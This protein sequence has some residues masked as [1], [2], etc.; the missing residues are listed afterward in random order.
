MKQLPM[1]FKPTR[2]KK[3]ETRMIHV[4]VT[5]AERERIERYAKKH[6][7]GNVGEYIRYAVGVAEERCGK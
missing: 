2:E 1:R 3:P 5:E 4:R 6:F 7:G